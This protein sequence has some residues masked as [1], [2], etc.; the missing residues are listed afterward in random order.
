MLQ[1]DLYPPPP[2]AHVLSVASALFVYVGVG[3]VVGQVSGAPAHVMAC[4]YAIAFGLMITLLA[5]SFGDVSGAH[6]NPAVTLALTLT[7]NVRVIRGL[8]YMV[9]QCLGGLVGGG[10]LFA[11]VGEQ[12]YIS[13]IG[14]A[15]HLSAA[16][17]FAHELVG[18]FTLV[19]TVF[20]VAVRAGKTNPN[21][22]TGVVIHALAPLPIGFA[23]LV[24]HLVLGPH[25]GC[26]IN[27]A[28]VI[29]AVAYESEAWWAGHTGQAFWIYWVG[30]FTASIAA[31]VVYALLYG[32]V[33]PGGKLG[34]SVIGPGKGGRD[35]AVTPVPEKAV[36][37]KYVE[38]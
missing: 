19:L 25:T 26:G 14:L 16:Q 6:I 15:P 18:T 36:D 7:G 10:V 20:N 38:K 21:D 11:A 8:L 4:N 12:K 31:P 24:V 30:P 1:A 22:I 33:K 35:S 23:V 37:E 2:P 5:F 27:P 28:R 3:S 34:F 29:G 32:T 13:G 17:G 9:F